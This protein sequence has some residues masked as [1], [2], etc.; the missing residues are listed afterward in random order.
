M[1]AFASIIGGQGPEEWS[2]SSKELSRI[3]WMVNF[4][5]VRFIAPFECARCRALEKMACQE[6]IDATDFL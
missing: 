2:H 3:C 5:R 4:F 1:T 6:I